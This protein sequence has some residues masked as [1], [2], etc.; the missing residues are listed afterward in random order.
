M[1]VILYGKRHFADVIKDFEMGEYPDY[2]GGAN[3]IK[4]VLRRRR[5]KGQLF[6]GQHTHFPGKAT[7]KELEISA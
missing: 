7:H 4:K 5:H 3:I 1:N 2:P 6:R